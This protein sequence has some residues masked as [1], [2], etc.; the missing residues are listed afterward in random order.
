MKKISI[1]LSMA[2]VASSFAFTSCDDDDEVKVEDKAKE[3]VEENAQTADEDD[4]Y[5]LYTYEKTDWELDDK[6]VAKA[7]PS[8]IPSKIPTVTTDVNAKAQ[9]LNEKDIEK[10]NNLP[11]IKALNVV[12]QEIN[13]KLQAY[14]VFLQAEAGDLIAMETSDGTKGVAKVLSVSSDHKK[15]SVKCYLAVPKE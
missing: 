12:Q 2:L 7:D 1:L 14:L 15:I 9:I 6:D 10:Y 5:I 13:G 4:F 11:A 3:L 8:Q